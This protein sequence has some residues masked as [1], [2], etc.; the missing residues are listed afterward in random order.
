MSE[1]QVFALPTQGVI[2][3]KLAP[4]STMGVIYLKLAPNSDFDSQRKAKK[5]NQ[6]TAHDRK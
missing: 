2:Y 4:N 6:A 1:M 3:P 5:I